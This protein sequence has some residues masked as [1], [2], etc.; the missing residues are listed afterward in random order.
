MSR[1]RFVFV[2]VTLVLLYMIFRF[3]QV[4][5]ELRK[6]RFIEKIIPIFLVLFFHFQSKIKD[7]FDKN[8]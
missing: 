3:Y 6:L 5:F 8:K 2:L 7:Y 1:Y 4:K